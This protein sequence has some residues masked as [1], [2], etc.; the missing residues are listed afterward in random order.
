MQTPVVVNGFVYFGTTRTVPSFYKLSPSGKLVW[1]YV[2]DSVI[3]AEEK[4][5]YIEYGAENKSD[6]V[7]NAAVIY[8]DR[9]F[10]GTFGGQVICLDRFNGKL[11]WRVKTKRPPFPSAHGANT[12]MSSPII[13]DGKLIVAGGGFEHGLAAIPEYP[14]CTGRGFVA[15]FEPS[16][17][18]VLWIYDVGPQT[19]TIS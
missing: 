15:A 12:I 19:G 3:T 4:D 2:I 18:E 6:G 11:L 16:T 14:C 1:K 8:G 10:F 9:V 17:G 5:P 13:A 7:M